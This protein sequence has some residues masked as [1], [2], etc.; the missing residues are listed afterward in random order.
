MLGIRLRLGGRG[1]GVRRRRPAAVLLFAAALSLGC[2]GGASS[3]LAAVNAQETL[4]YMPTELVHSIWTT[5]QVEGFLGNLNSYDIGQALL[6]MPHFK[7]KGT[8][9]L[10]ASNE[11]MLGVWSRTAAAYNAEHGTQMAVTAVFN[12]KLTAKGPSVE[13]PATRRNMIAAIESA[14]ATGISGVQLDLEP[15]PVTA[16]YISLLEEVDAAFARLGFHGRLSVVAPAETSTWAPAY[17]LRVT[18]L[19]SQVDPTYYDSEITNAPEYEAWVE[20][21][22]AYYS[23]NSAPAVRIVPVIPSYARDPWH[24]PAVENIANATTALAGAL[25]EGSRVNGAGIWW[26]YGFFYNKPRF[27]ASADRAAWQSTT[28]SLAFTP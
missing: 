21:S 10:P 1:K 11:E 16:G 5:A 24:L 6:Q 8:I 26:W 25:S 22:L 13:N 2:A 14:I 20:Q 28:T 7:K 9:V 23:A 15:Y 18:K 12:G 3:A 4:T 19:V 17:L 27:N